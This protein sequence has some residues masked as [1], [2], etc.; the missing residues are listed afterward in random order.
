MASPR[1]ATPGTCVPIR[2]GPKQGAPESPVLWNLL[3]DEALG[4]VL[5]E[6]EGGVC[7]PAL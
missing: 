4:A 5:A 7:L 1:M 3:V 2:K 6:L